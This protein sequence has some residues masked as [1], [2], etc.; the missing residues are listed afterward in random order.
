[1]DTPLFDGKLVHSSRIIYTPSPF[2]RASLLHL[3]EV[4]SLQ[5]RQPHDSARKD[6]SSY[7][8]FLVEHGSGLLEYEGV[9]HTLNAGDC[10]FLDCRKP[11]LHRTGKD[12]W[13]LRWAH[14]FGPNMGAIYKK[15]QERGGQPVFRPRNPEHFA[16]LL[17]E[18]YRL[19]SSDDYVRDMQNKGYSPLLQM[20]GGKQK[21]GKTEITHFS[22]VQK[23][24]KEK[25]RE[26]LRELFDLSVPFEQCKDAEYCTYCDFKKICRR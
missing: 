9:C 18:L 1:M 25:L 11:Y 8:F 3:Q 19:A 26:T 22:M 7:L 16:Q 15:Y 21:P 24:F 17:Q 10:V 20:G 2:A 6:L 13:T 14:F 12:L 23:E 4:G 5:A